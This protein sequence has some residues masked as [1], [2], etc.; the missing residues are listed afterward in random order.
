[1][2]SIKPHF[3]S[4]NSFQL[5]EQAFKIEV[6]MLLWLTLFFVFYRENRQSCQLTTS[7]FSLSVNWGSDKTAADVEVL[8]LVRQKILQELSE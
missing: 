8:S 3:L 1:M 6:D 4:A 7:I 5:S 2:N